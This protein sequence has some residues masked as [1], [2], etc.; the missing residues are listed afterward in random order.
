MQ[1]KTLLDETD[2]AIFHAVEIAP[3]ASWATVGAAVGVDPVTAARRW[4]SMQ[5]ANLAWVTCYPLLTRGMAAAFLQIQCKVAC[6]RAVAAIIAELPHAMTVEI[7]SGS[8]DIFMVACAKSHQ[9]LSELIL[10]SLPR[11]PGVEKIL[12]QP[13][14]ATHLDRGLAAAGS[15]EPGSRSRLPAHDRGT[16]VPST[17]RTDDLDWAICMELSRDG[18]SSV[19]ALARAV[20]ASESSVKRRVSKLI[21]AGALHVRA[22][23]APAAIPTSAIVWI[24]LRVPAGDVGEAVSRITAL[25]GTTYL[26]L[27]AGPTNM[28]VRVALPHLAA[29]EAFEAKIHHI[30]PRIDIEGRMVVLEIVRYASRTFDK[31]GRVTGT[32]SNDIRASSP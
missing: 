30:N 16:L 11:I 4:D 32:A 14:V 24:G 9:D 1:E 13:T 23:L 12:S 27:A 28:H 21:S 10:E 26:G 6:V 29:L 15:M 17:G 5:E 25:T 2:L 7:V 8:S 3:R 22:A 19:A 31:H 18:R 20:G